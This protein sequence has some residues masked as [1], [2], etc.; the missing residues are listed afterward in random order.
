[1]PFLVVFRNV[2]QLALIITSNT[3]A[4]GEERRLWGDHLPYYYCFSSC[5][6]RQSPLY[7]FKGARLEAR[8]WDGEAIDLESRVVL[9][10]GWQ[11]SFSEQP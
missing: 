10:N 6:R 2:S 3:R 4:P 7:F 8:V 1:M 9:Q 5:K 11:R